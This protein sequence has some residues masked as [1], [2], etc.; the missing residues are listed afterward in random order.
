MSEYVSKVRS[1]SFEQLQSRFQSVL[2]RSSFFTEID[3]QIVR[4]LDANSR[5]GRNPL[6]QAKHALQKQYG[7][8]SIP[9]PIEQFL[10]VMFMAP[11]SARSR[12]IDKLHEAVDD[13]ENY[14]DPPT[15]IQFLLAISQEEERILR[16]ESAIQ[17]VT[18]NAEA[19]RREAIAQVTHNMGYC[20]E[21][22][23]SPAQVNNPW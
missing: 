7:L 11:T 15:I 10:A 1:L 18:S 9:S 20:S 22:K 16:R 19:I 8:D 2:E 3:A 4:A 17:Q 21:S 13:L 23:S 14:P 5:L 12:M 6:D